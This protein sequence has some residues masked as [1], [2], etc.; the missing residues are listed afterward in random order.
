MAGNVVLFIVEGPTDKD[1]LIPYI[2]QEFIDMKLKTTVQ[3][4]HGDVLTEY[5]NGKRQ[6]KVRPDN[7]RQELVKSISKYFSEPSK[8]AEQIKLKDI[9]NIYYIT[10]TDY[11][12]NKTFPHS[13]NKKQCLKTM[14]YF[15]NIELIKNNPIPFKIIFFAKHLEHIIVDEERDHTD[16]EKIKIAMEFGEKSLIEEGVFVKTFRNEKIKT[17]KT[18]K[19][20]YNGIKVYIGRACN[21]NNLLDEIDNWKE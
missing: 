3:I 19:E 20:S 11:C 15:E 13:L 17:W 16:E 21:M 5:E 9:K 2:E 1:A 4:M 7:L 14:F 18:Y 12:F 10:D 8:K 6:Y